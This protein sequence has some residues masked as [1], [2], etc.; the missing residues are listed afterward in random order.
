MEEEIKNKKE[1][2]LKLFD[3]IFKT[4]VKE[5]VN[6][7]KVPLISYIYNE[8]IRDFMKVDSNYRKS[9]LKTIKI[10]DKIKRALTQKQ[11]ELLNEYLDLETQLEANLEEQLFIFGYIFAKELENE[12]TLL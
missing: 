4:N 7:D 12:N 8:L 3:E 10:Y 6:L 1:E 2:Y 5:K 11:L 9:K